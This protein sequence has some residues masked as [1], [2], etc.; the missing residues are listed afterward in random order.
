MVWTDL[1]WGCEVDEPEGLTESERNQMSSGGGKATGP[2]VLFVYFTCTQ[3][4][5]KVAEAMAGVLRERGCDVR[6][7]GI[8]LRDSR[9]SERFTR[10]PLRH[11]YGDIVGMMPAQVREATG[12][13][14]VPEEAR[15]G[16][17]DLAAKTETVNATLTNAVRKSVAQVDGGGAKQLKAAL[18]QAQA[19]MGG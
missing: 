14:G 17:Y 18:A 19:G 6:L 8:E 3:Q 12:E 13:I 9:W 4:S 5:L 7:A 1:A 15:D 11:P 10:F 16:D 2:K